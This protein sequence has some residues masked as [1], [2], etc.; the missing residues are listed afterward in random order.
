[1]DSPARTLGRRKSVNLD[2]GEQ[3]VRDLAR[4]RYALRVFLRFSEN[5]A[6]ECGVTPQQH[7]IMLGVAGFSAR[8]AATISELA[9][10][11]QAR[12]HSVVGLV[13]RAARKGLVRSVQDDED[14][15]VVRVFL[16]P[17]GKRIL[18][19]LVALH[20]GEVSRMKVM[21]ESRIV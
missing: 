20:R 3:L 1:M 14:R 18:A 10:F 4:F 9:E 2:G 11:L 13:R 7:Q 17:A 16:T 19:R 5:A 21:M 15:R 12:H 6:R 8:G